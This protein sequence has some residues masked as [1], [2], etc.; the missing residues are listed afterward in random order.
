MGNSKSVFRLLGYAGLIPFVLGALLVVSGSAY[1]PVAGEVVEAYA[2]GIVCFLCGSWWG[3]AYR[4]DSVRAFWL[5]NLV[6]LLAFFIFV[7]ARDWW[8]LAAAILLMSM[9]F[10]EQGGRLFPAFSGAYRH[11]R[12]QLTAVASLSMLALQ[13]ASRG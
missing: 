10:S 7:A 13:F 6:F 3:L 1:A 5:S 11:L 8:P 9:L 12:I 2:F 4:D